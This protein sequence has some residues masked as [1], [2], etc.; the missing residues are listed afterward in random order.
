VRF[1]ACSAFTARYG[2]HTRQVTKMTLYT[3]GFDCFVTSTAAPIATGW[4]DS[5][6]AGLS[7]AEEPRLF[8]AHPILCT[9]DKGP[10][11]PYT[12]HGNSDT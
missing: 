5:C 9:N 2:L 1:E 3:E 10:P 4:S 12:D 6:R 8:T 11:S 7:P